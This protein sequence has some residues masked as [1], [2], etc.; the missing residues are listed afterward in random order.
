M[1][2]LPKELR[3][4]SDDVVRTGVL[5]GVN[6]AFTAA[7]TIFAIAESSFPSADWWLTWTQFSLLFVSVVLDWVILYTIDLKERNEARG[8]Y[9]KA[10]QD[11]NRSLWRQCEWIIPVAC[12]VV[13]IGFTIAGLVLISLDEHE[14][15]SLILRAVAPIM[16]QLLAG[17]AG[18]VVR[19]EIDAIERGL[20]RRKENEAES[21]FSLLR[22]FKELQ[23]PPELAVD[24]FDTQQVVNA[25]TAAHVA[26]QNANQI[27]RALRGGSQDHSFHQSRHRLC[28]CADLHHECSHLH[29]ADRRCETGCE[30]R[31]ETCCE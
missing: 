9:V 16:S 4:I 28:G 15:W 5:R 8:D 31:G 3:D 21:T 1:R 30:S 24:R 29:Q 10:L 2:H 23:Q 17:Q 7:A 22:I 13:S 25:K 27:L 6:S 18:S 12:A 20:A 11:G 14:Q 26:I 19:E